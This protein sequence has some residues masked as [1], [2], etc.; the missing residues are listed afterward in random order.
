MNEVRVNLRKVESGDVIE[1]TLAESV[2]REIDAGNLEF[3]GFERGVAIYA[4]PRKHR[5]G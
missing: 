5:T 1:K 2:Q 4:P 3:K